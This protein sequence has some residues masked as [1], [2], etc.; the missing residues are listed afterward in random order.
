MPLRWKAWIIVVLLACLTGCSTVQLGYNQG[1]TLA[2]WWLDAQ[3]DF[4]SAQRQPVQDGLERWF[5]WHRATQLPELADRL[6]ALRRLA[7]GKVTARQVCAA[8]D[9]AQQRL[10][11]WYARL[12]PLMV[13]PAKTLAPAQIDHLAAKYAQDIARLRDDILQPDLALRRAAQRKRT[14]ERFEE[15]YGRLSAAQQERIAAALEAAPFDSARWL[16]ERRQRQLDIVA[17]LRRIAAAQPDDATV[18]AI[19][20]GFG[21]DAAVSPRPDYRAWQQQRMRD[22]CELVAAVH[23][24]IDDAQRQ[25]VLDRLR[26]W[27]DDARALAAQRD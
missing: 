21:A 12:V 19:L 23:D 17:G 25:R 3:F 1:P 26:G 4:D 13:A 11:R 24:G 5:E 8:W 10:L 20:L 6:A 7:G 16:A 22:G 9:D 2:W 15:F 14:V 18:A 27:E